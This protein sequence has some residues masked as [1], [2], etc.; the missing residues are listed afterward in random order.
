M[1]T[2]NFK[3]E[4][5]VVYHTS[6]FTGTHDKGVLALATKVKLSHASKSNHPQ[7]LEHMEHGFVI[8]SLDISFTKD[9]VYEACGGSS[10]FCQNAF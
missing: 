5:L 8:L 9:P 7:F 3:G 4:A 10:T 1:E 6:K 2:K